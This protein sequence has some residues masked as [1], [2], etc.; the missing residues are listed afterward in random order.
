MSDETIPTSPEASGVTS[1]KNENSS[2]NID[3][4]Y[5]LAQKY[6]EEHPDTPIVDKSPTGMV[7]A[8]LQ[9]QALNKYNQTNQ[10]QAPQETQQSAAPQQQ[11]QSSDLFSLLFDELMRAT[12]HEAMHYH[13][14]CACP[15][16][17]FS[18]LSFAL[19]P[20][21]ADCHNHF[22]HRIDARD[23]HN[24]IKTRIGTYEIGAGISDV[25]EG[26]TGSGITEALS[27]GLKIASVALDKKRGR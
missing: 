22:C 17:H 11:N 13:C 26:N 9:V 19:P 4:L 24:R 6:F 5:N 20:H 27:G 10:Q 2:V 14:H 18:H 8:Y 15:H 21:M 7:N 23:A 16:G 1:S 25:I 12:I 3:A